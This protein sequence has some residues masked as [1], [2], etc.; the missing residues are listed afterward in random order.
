MLVAVSRRMMLAMMLSVVLN[1]ML[2][3]LLLMIHGIA[4]R[5]S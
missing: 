3:V 1:M 2:N 4:L 5:Y